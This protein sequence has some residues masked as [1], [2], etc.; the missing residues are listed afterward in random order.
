MFTE[1][2][3][4]KFPL[5]QEIMDFTLDIPVIKIPLRKTFVQVSS[6]VAHLYQHICFSCNSIYVSR[7]KQNQQQTSTYKM[8]CLGL[9][10]DKFCTHYD[11]KYAFTIYIL[12]SFDLSTPKSRRVCSKLSEAI[13]RCA[14][15]PSI[16]LSVSREGGKRETQGSM[17]SQI[18]HL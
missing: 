3:T 17:Y 8:G 16:V 7:D 11:W 14:D 1:G 2:G 10:T 6:N 15:T 12:Q 18:V 4:A 9:A 5:L 13:V